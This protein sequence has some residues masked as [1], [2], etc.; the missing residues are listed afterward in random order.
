MRKLQAESVPRARG[1]GLLRSPVDSGL[2]DAKAKHCVLQVHD[3]R[4]S[5]VVWGSGCSGGIGVSI[6]LEEKSLIMHSSGNLG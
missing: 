1:T 3:K 5:L 2:T 4:L 6:L